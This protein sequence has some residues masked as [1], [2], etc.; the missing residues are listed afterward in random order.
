MSRELKCDDRY[1]ILDFRWHSNPEELITSWFNYQFFYLHYNHPWDSFKCLDWK[2]S[3]S[4]GFQNFTQKIGH[5]ATNNI[6]NNRGRGS[7]LP[8]GLVHC[9]IP[10]QL[11]SISYSYNYATWATIWPA[12]MSVFICTCICTIRCL[13]AQIPAGYV[14]PLPPPPPKGFCFPP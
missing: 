1:Q 12:G 11:D 13:T 4:H 10:T 9:T 8:R 7:F 3:P 14:P 6:I 2:I 5:E